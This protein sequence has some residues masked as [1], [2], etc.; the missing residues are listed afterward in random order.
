MKKSEIRIILLVLFFCSID[1]ISKAI[2]LKTGNVLYNKIIIKNFFSIVLTKNTGAA[3]SFMTGY[4]WVF[5]IIAILVLIFF[6]KYYISKKDLNKLEI[7]SY[8]LLI[9]GIIGNL[10]DR[11]INGFVVD[12]LSFKIFGYYFPVF[13]FADTF[14]VIGA[15]ILIISTIRSD[16]NE[17]RSK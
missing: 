9:G 15:I 17:V 10:I 14:I 3:F 4:S 13:N 12:F 8:S 1:L 2:I 6:I 7:I 5:V 16:K 11:I